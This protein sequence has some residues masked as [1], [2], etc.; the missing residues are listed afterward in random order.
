[1]Y[2]SDQLFIAGERVPSSGG[3]LLEVTNPSTEELVARIPEPSKEDIDRAVTSARRSFDQGSWRSQPLDERIAVLSKSLALLDSKVEE[4]ARMVT[5]EM[6]APLNSTVDGTRWGLLSAQTLLDDA[7]SLVLEEVRDGRWPALI[8][9]EP[10]GVIAAIAPWNGPWLMAL[11]K[12]LSGLVVGC[13]VVLKPAPETPLDALLIGEALVDAGLP[14]GVLSILGG[15]SAVGE[16]LVSHADVDKVSFTGS[17]AAGRRVAA[18]CGQSLKRV[19]LELGG[20]S[21]AIVLDDVDLTKALPALTSGAFMNNGQVCAATSRVLAPESRY[22]EVVDALVEMADML[23]VGD[24]LDPATDLGP[25]VTERQRDRVE[26]FIAAGLNEGARLVAGGRRPAGLD[27][28][29]FVSPTVFAD[30]DNHMSIA[31]E[32]IFGPVLVVIPYKSQDEA[33]EIANDSLYGLHGAVFT[34]DD[35]RALYVAER[36]RTG[37]FSVNRFQLNTS[38]PFGGM[39]N[40]GIGREYGREG[41]IANLE[42]KTVNLSH[43]LASKLKLV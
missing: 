32:E 2:E 22:G 25:L 33:V 26:G 20:K 16:S 11:N 37:T 5:A 1:M 13:S 12:I 14:K 18:L 7:Q 4:I 10:V 28:G 9:Q 17:T 42:C 19:Q 36:V 34:N 38:Q 27:R 40:S 23:R 3:A 21:A 8:R 43:E 15:G 35:E 6:G 41:L 30:V 24:P 39:K 31:Q 29:W